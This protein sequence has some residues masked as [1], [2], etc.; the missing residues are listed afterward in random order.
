MKQLRF[1][2][3]TTCRPP[4]PKLTDHRV[5]EAI[6]RRI[7]AEV[8]LGDFYWEPEEIETRVWD[9][10]REIMRVGRPESVFT[11]L[12]KQQPPVSCDGRR[13]GH[14]YGWDGIDEHCRHIADEIAE[15]EL[16]AAV[17]WWRQRYR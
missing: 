1:P 9:V 14:P 3:M 12:Y 13:G 4:K 16:Q 15:Q 5:A 8:N 17:H 6:A 7:V 11:R 10:T 2:A